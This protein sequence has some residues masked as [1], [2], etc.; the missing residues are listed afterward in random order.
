MKPI[1][2]KITN[3]VN[4]KIY[5]GLTRRALKERWATHCYISKTKP[6]CYLHKAIAKY[7][8]D[9]FTIEYIANAL[10]IN[11]GSKFEQQVIKQEKPNYNLTNGGECTKGRKLMAE[12][13]LKIAFANKGK[14]RTLEMN[15]AN[16]AQAKERYLNNPEYKQ[17]IL[18]SLFKAHANRLQ[19]EDKRLTAVRQAA[20]NGKMSRPLT[21]ERK[22]IQLANITSKE[23]RAKMAKSK[24]KKVICVTTGEVYESILEAGIKIGIHFTSISKICLGKQKTAKGLKFEFLKN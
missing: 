6:V 4:N 19:Y 9:K 8:A 17:K 14:K 3:T 5:I 16:S 23:A 18:N 2:Y 20:K 22:A 15:A 12:T 1:I 24:Q 13:Y 7:G 10:S 11:D 21:E